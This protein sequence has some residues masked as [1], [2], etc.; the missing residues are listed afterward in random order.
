[1]V[2]LFKKVSKK[3]GLPPGTPVFIGDRKEDEVRIT[4]VDYDAEHFEMR[5]AEGVQECTPYKEKE[6]VTWI[7]I[8]GLHDITVQQRL[9]ESFGL[10]PLIVEDILNTD[11]R[12][13]VDIFD[14]YIFIVFKML[15]YNRETETLDVEQVSLILG[16]NFVIT[17]QERAGDIF[18]PVRSRLRNNKGRIRKMG[19]DFLVYSLMDAVVDGYYKVLENIGEEIEELE[20][21]LVEHPSPETLQSIHTLKKEMIF[22]RRSVWPLR[23]VIIGMEREES[24]LIRET[25]HIYL[26]DLYDHTIQVIDTTE[27]FRDIIAG[28][29]DVYLSIISN[30]MNEVM[31]VLTIFAVIFIPMTFIAGIYG[32]NFNTAKSPFNMPELN[33]YF[34]YPLALGIMA[35]IA[36]VMV[37]YFRKK[38]WI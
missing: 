1:M 12:T 8:D 29:L 36:I 7:N 2:T 32:M 25:T 9:G 26:R 10:H 5:E 37:I 31:K 14:D 20:E 15:L 22:L 6:T 19:A 24:S 38:E 4:I 30:R 34:G 28:M 3:A 27:T 17:F 35:A 11:Q 16:N 23:E 13:K 18:E 21:E 33:W